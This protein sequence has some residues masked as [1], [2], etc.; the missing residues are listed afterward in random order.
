MGTLLHVPWRAAP[1]VYGWAEL[2]SFA[3]HAAADE[4]TATWRALNPDA[5]AWASRVGI[6]TVMACVFDAAAAI[7]H[8][9]ATRWARDG[10]K[11]KPPKPFPLPWRRESGSERL[12]RDPIPVADFDAWYYDQTE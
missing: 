11:P 7:H 4:S 2:A 8:A 5:A 9:L 1:L 6:V 12:G 10:I 3:R